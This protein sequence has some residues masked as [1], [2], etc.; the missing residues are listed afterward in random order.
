MEKILGT[1]IIGFLSILFVCGFLASIAEYLIFLT[2]ILIVPVVYVSMSLV[3]KYHK[4]KIKWKEL[5]FKSTLLLP[6]K[7]GVY[8]IPTDTSLERFVEPVVEIAK[9]YHG[10]VEVVPHTLTYAPRLTNTGVEIDNVP[11]ETITSILPPYS[12]LPFIDGKILLGY[13][14]D[15]IPKHVERT[16]LISTLVGGQ[17]DSGKST[18]MR[19]ILSQYINQGAAIAIIDPHYNAGKDSL[20][21]SFDHTNLFSPTSYDPSDIRN[22]L[23]IFNLEISERLKG[24]E[25]DTPLIL[26][27]DEFTGLLSNEDT[28]DEIISTVNKIS[29]ES[30]KVKIYCYCIA[31]QFHKDLIPSVLRNGFTTFL[32]TRSRYEVAHLLSGSKIFAKEVE[33]I[34]GYQ[35]V[36]LSKFGELDRLNVPN[37]TQNDIQTIT[38]VKSSSQSSTNGSS[39]PTNSKDAYVIAMLKLGKS[40]GEIVREVYQVDGKGKAYQESIIDIRRI[41]SE[42]I[43]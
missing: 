10:T 39:L 13:S 42:N 20:G 37:T 17:T 21:K 4:N 26:V 27:I 34:Q 18:L 5:N 41:I 33:K 28:R 30:R 22:T 16:E 24:K 2:P 40:S 1:I 8:P 43:N 11:R 31:Q 25:S 36:Y 12:Q 9:I 3:S 14:L 6:D 35:C 15:N 7:N 29:S 23:S 38:G 19:L 32:S